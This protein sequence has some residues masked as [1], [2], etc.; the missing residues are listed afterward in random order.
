MFDG[1]VRTLTDVRHVPNLKRNLI[2]FSTLDLNM[3]KFIGECGVIRVS[4]GVLI[5]IKCMK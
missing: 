1:I 3:Y 4:S 5:M 2:S